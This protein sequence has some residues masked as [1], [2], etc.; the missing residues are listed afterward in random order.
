[1]VDL[2]AAAAIVMQTHYQPSLENYT[3]STPIIGIS[4]YTDTCAAYALSA[5]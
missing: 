2:A 3:T 4:E 5:L 1:M